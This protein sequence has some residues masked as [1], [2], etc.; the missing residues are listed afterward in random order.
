MAA[1]DQAAVLIFNSKFKSNVYLAK[2]AL[3][4]PNA[5]AYYN[6]L[7]RNESISR[8]NLEELHWERLKVLLH[9]A[10]DHSRYYRNTFESNGLHPSD[11]KQP[12]DFSLVPILTRAGLSDHFTDIVSDEAKFS[13]LNLV[14]TGGSTG[15]PVKVF[16]QKSVARIAT[17]WR[18]QRWWNIPPGSDMGTVYRAP[19]T[20]ASRI[21]ARLISWPNRQVQL[22]AAVFD[23]RSMELF[24][25]RFDKLRPPLLHGYVGGVDCLASFILD[26][27]RKIHSP[28]AIWVTSAPLTRVQEQRIEKAFDAPVYDQYGCCEVFYLS[29]ECPRKEGLHI[30]HDLRRIEFLDELNQPVTDGM[31]GN[32]AITDFE[33]LHFPLIR[34]LTGDQGRALTKVCSCGIVLP[35]MDKVRGRQSDLIRTPRNI[36]IRG[37]VLTRLFDDSPDAVRQ[38]QVH[39]LRDHSI[40]LRVIPNLQ[41]TGLNQVLHVACET[42]AA[43]TNHEVAITLEKVENIPLRRGKPRYV[44]SDLTAADDI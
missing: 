6:E 15:Q 14:T 38:F 43:V 26:R 39:Q 30:F 42:L 29:A 7:V 28:R 23:D 22:D 16:H 9:Y 21:K 20:R 33:N 35:L 19:D 31:I 4:K 41:Y 32:I 2:Y 24:L 13:N 17:L 40:R 18:M 10:Y 5:L 27:G 36:I 37:E 11:I 25:Q 44:I 34:Y 12:S 1:M 3:G 8:E